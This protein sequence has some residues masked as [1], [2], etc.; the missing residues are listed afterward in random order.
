MAEFSTLMDAARRSGSEDAVRIVEVLHQ[1]ND[2]LDDIDWKE[3]NSGMVHKTTL[4]T[5]LP[6]PVWRMLN[7]GVPTGK[8]TSKQISAGCGMLEIYAEVDKMQVSLAARGQVDNA[9]SNAAAA[10]A[11][12]G[13]NEAFIEGFGQELARVL[14]YG[15][16]SKPQEPVGLTHY[17]NELGG[18]TAKNIIDAGGTGSDNTSIWL[19]AWGDRSIHGIYPQGSKAGLSENFLGEVTLTDEDGN[20]YQGY[21]THYK[22]DNGLVVRDHRC[23]VRICNVDMAKLLTGATGAA[24]LVDL[25]ATAKYRLPKKAIAGCRLAF[26]ARPEILEVLDRQTRKTNNLMLDYSTVYGR[27]VNTFRGIPIRTQEAIL[28]S[29]ARVQ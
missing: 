6:T 12:A 25:M 11:L 16:P 29:E 15:D 20:M 7:R 9:S 5:S 21:R 14:L 27:E 17:Y 23:A 2:I 28:D 13:E 22:W 26:Y 3:C 8:S 10:H 19:V 1:T 18:E 24:D 4:R